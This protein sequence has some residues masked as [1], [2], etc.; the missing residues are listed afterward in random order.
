MNEDYADPLGQEFCCVI[1]N[2]LNPDIIR[3]AVTQT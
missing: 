2:F 1:C 3:R